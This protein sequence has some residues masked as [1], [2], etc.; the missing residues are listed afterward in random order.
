MEEAIIFWLNTKDTGSQVMMLEELAYFYV[1]N[2][3]L[4]RT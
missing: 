1:V 4:N 2:S 3:I